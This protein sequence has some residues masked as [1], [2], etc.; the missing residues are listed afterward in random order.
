MIEI[1]SELPEVYLQPGEFF[2]ARSPSILKT[3][4]GS[5]VGITFHIPRLGIGALCHGILPRSPKGTQA[6]EGYR[7]VDYAIRD[8]ARQFDASGAARSEVQV[9]AFGGGDVIPG[10]FGLSKTGTVGF[11]NW[12]AALEVLEEEG[13]KVI[14]QDLGDTVGRVIQFHTGTGEV[15]VRRLQSSGKQEEMIRG[16]DL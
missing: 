8:L 5:C 9:K 14:A 4:L 12:G 15:L 11:Q 1:V 13:F 7:Y 16:S 10:L 2:L 3:V 6:A